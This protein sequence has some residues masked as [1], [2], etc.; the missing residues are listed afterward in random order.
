MI[1]VDL[2]LDDPR[3]V[4]CSWL[5]RWN[6]PI[7]FAYRVSGLVKVKAASKS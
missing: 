7:E 5:D 1:V 2:D 3:S 4:I 6:C